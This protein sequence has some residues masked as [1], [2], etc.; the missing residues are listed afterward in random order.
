MTFAEWV[1]ARIKVASADIVEAYADFG[2]ELDKGTVKAYAEFSLGAAR[3]MREAGGGSLS[4]INSPTHTEYLREMALVA[5]G[6]D[7]EIISKIIGDEFLTGQI[8]R[9]ERELREEEGTEL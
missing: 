2:G 8:I 7:E 5:G 3:I 9:A 1:P 4:P 6:A